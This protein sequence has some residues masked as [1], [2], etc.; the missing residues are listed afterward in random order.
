MLNSARCCEEDFLH[1]GKSSVISGIPSF[2]VLLSPS[3]HSFFL[4]TYRMPVIPKAEILHFESHLGLPHYRSVVAEY[5]SK[6]TNDRAAVQIL[7][8]MT[9][10]LWNDW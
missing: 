9:V 8:D 3:V 7:M 10:C 2:L 1:Q 6:T 5:R 4:R